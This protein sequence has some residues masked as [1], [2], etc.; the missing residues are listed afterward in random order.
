MPMP[1]WQAILFDVNGTLIDI[2]TD[3][4]R[5]ESYVAISRFLRYQGMALAPDR[6]RAGYFEIIGQQQAASAEAH[7]EV[8]VVAAWRAVLLAQAPV[9]LRGLPPAM[10][11]ALPRVLAQLQRSLARNRLQLYPDVRRVLDALRPR[12]RLGIVT[13]AQRAYTAAELCEV[14]LLDL[15]AVRVI[16]DH[17]GYRKPDARLF[18]AAL[19]ALQVPADRALYVGNDMYRDVF[20]A[21]QAGMQAAFFPTQ[22]GAHEH[23][24]V[25]PD[26][27]L[28]RFA[29]LLEIVEGGQ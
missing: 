2:E 18:Q 9:A 7:P 16:S 19:A 20:G 10:R 24:G 4:E 3:E 25:V 22:Y 21:Q 26:Y 27:R 8:D 29:D 11:R 15:F 14:G 5:L 28:A 6:L 17:Y 23:A 13:D 12:V 1:D